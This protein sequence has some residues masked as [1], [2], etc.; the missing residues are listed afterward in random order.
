MN[1][2]NKWLLVTAC[3]SVLFGCDVST[4]GACS[5]GGGTQQQANLIDMADIQGM[6]STGVNGD[7][8]LKLEP[9]ADGPVEYTDYVIEVGFSYELVAQ[10][11][12]TVHAPYNRSVLA[13]GL[14]FSFISSAHACSGG[15]YSDSRDVSVL[16]K[17]V[18]I[19]IQSDADFDASHAAGDSLAAQF[20]ISYIDSD[21][22]AVYL[23]LATFV[24]TDRETPLNFSLHLA[25]APD[26]N[27]QHEFTVTVT[28]DSGETYARQTSAVLL[29]QN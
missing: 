8:L 14:N 1:T 19:D 24:E 16:N 3:A 28:T 10:Q 21:G 12:P 6:Q 22:L 18:N 9:L 17:M 23:P 26:E 13:A 7:G 2:T 27:S 29:T 25:A 11:G 15:G 5:S 20:N 4:P